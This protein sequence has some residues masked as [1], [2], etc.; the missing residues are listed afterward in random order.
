MK[1]LTILWISLGILL[2][3][4]CQGSLAEDDFPNIVEVDALP[5]DFPEV[6]VSTGGFS[7]KTG[8]RE[9]SGDRPTHRRTY[10]SSG[11]K[12]YRPT[13]TTSYRTSETGNYRPTDTTRY[14]TSETGNYRPTDTTNYRTSETGNYRPTVNTNYRTSETEND[15]STNG[16]NYRPTGTTT[17]RTSSSGRRQY[18]PHRPRPTHTRPRVSPGSADARGDPDPQVPPPPQRHGGVFYGKS[19]VPSTSRRGGSKRDRTSSSSSSYS[20][21]SSSKSTRTGADGAVLETVSGSQYGTPGSGIENSSYSYSHTHEGPGSS[22]HVTSSS[23]GSE[24]GGDVSSATGSS[25][26]SRGRG[27][28]RGRSRSRSKSRG[29]SRG[30]GRGRARGGT[31]GGDEDTERPPVVE[32]PYFR[33]EV[34]EGEDGRTYFRWN[35]RRYPAGGKV[36]TGRRITSKT[37]KTTK[38]T[39]TV[40]RDGKP[41]VSVTTYTSPGRTSVTTYRNSTIYTSHTPGGTGQDHLTFGTTGTTGTTGHGT[42]SSSGSSSTTSSTTRWTSGSSSSSATTAGGGGGEGGGTSDTRY[43][44]HRYDSR[45]GVNRGSGVGFGEGY[46]KSTEQ[47][48]LEYEEEEFDPEFARGP[49]LPE[50]DQN[51]PFVV[52]GFGSAPGSAREESKSRLYYPGFGDRTTH[53]CDQSSCYPATGNLLIG[54]EE[55]LFASST[56]G[57]YQRSR[58]CIVS[59]LKDQKKCFWC[60]SRSQ[61]DRS[62]QFSH[63]VNNIVYRFDPRTRRRSW[64]Q[65]DNGIQDVSIKLDLEAE[66]HFT[67]LIITF[68]TFRPAAMLIERSFDF[69]KTWKVY[70]YFAHNCADA[71]PGIPSG[72]P[73][74]I[75]DV[76][77]ESRYSAV[78]PSTEGEVI[79]RVLPP[80]IRIDNPYSDEVQNLLKITNLRVNF[81]KLHTLGDQLLDNRV[82]IKEKYYYAIYDMV[83]RGSCSCYGHASRCLPL[84]GV[85][86]QSDMVH[87]RC[88][89]THNTKG[90]NCEECQDFFNDL[91]WR[92]AVGKD[93][94]ACKKCNCNNHA[95]RCHFDENVYENSGRISGG[96]CDDCS[97][98]TQGNNCEQCIPYYYQD[99]SRDIRDPQ[100]CQ[101]CNCDPRGSIDDGICD[102][103]SDQI[104]GLLAGRCHC[105]TYVDGLKCD[106]CKAGYWN[107]TEENPEGCEV[108]TEDY[109]NQPKSEWPRK[110]CTCNLLGTVNN[111]GCD[112]YTGRCQCKRFVTGK[113]CNQ[114][115]PQHFGL[116]DHPDGCQP[117]NCDRGGAMDNDCDVITGQCKCRPHVTGRRCDQ[118]EEGYYV[119]S[120]NYL[121]YEAELAR[122]SELYCEEASL[123]DY[124][125]P[126]K[127][128]CQVV[129]REPYRD[130]RPTTWTGLGF[131]RVF[132]D[133]YLEF[134]IENVETSMEYD[135]VIRY[136]PQ[137]RN[138]WE[139]ARVIIERPGPVDPHGD[140]GNTHSTDDQIV[141]NL[142]DNQRDETLYPPVCLEAGKRYKIKIDFKRS[143]ALQ[144][145]AGASILVDS[146]LLIPRAERLPF[147]SGTAENDLLRREYE[148]YRCSQP[149]YS[150]G[151]N[152]ETIPEVCKDKHLESVGYYV[153]GQAFACQ[154][155]GTGSKSSLCDSFGGQC[156][157]KQNVVGRR[158]DRCAPGTYDF[159]PEG[160]KPCDCSSVGSL[161]NFCDQETGRCKCRPNTYGRQCDE[162]QPGFWNYPNCQRCEC[163]GHAD[164]CDSHTGKCHECR[165]NTS[166]PNCAYCIEGFYGDP[167]IDNGIACRPCPCPGT[168]DSGH[169]FADRCSLDPRTNDVVCEC[170]TGY[171]G[172]R[173]DACADNY[174]GNPEVPGGQCQS[175]Q[176]NNNIDIS[177]PGNCDARTGEC[178]QCLFNTYGNN[179]ER[180][181]PSYYGDALNQQCRQC[182][183]NLLGTETTED[184]CDH[185]TGQC[186]CLPNVLGQ[187]CDH[188]APNH[189]KIASGEG[190]EPC[191]CDPIGSYS[192]QCNEFD[193]QC[194]CKPGFGGRR[195]NQCQANFYGNPRVECLPCD[196]NRD[197]AETLQCDH[198]T[199]KCQCRLGI[200][201]HKCDVCDRGFTGR[202]PYCSPCG[203][204]FEN[205]D[206]ILEELKER[207][208][209]LI[210]AAS[211]IK[212]SGAT[213]AYSHEFESM[214]EHIEDV[215]EILLTANLTSQNLG[216]LEDLIDQLTES[217]SLSANELQGLELSVDNTTQRIS[218][219][220]TALVDLRL[221]AE[222]LRNKAGDLKEKATK[223]QEANVEGALNLT[224]IAE[225][226]SREAN[227][228]VDLTQIIVGES[229]RNRKRTELLL[230]HASDRFNRTQQENEDILSDLGL[231]LDE[232]EDSMP[233]LNEQVC[234]RRGN[235]CDAFC[236]G[237]GCN[238]KCGGLS[239]NDGLVNTAKGA[240]QFTEDAENILKKK[241]A[242]ADELLRGVSSAK[243][244][245]D[246]AFDL[247]K[248]AFDVAFDARNKSAGYKEAIQMLLNEIDEYYKTAGAKPD[249]IRILAEEVLKLDI[250]L[251]PE[252]ITALAEEIAST[253]DSLTNIDAIIDATRNDLDFANGLKERA[254]L[255]KAEAEG[256]LSVAE[257]VLKALEEAKAAQEA[258]EVALNTANNDVQ[259]ASTH[260]TQIASETS[261]AQTRASDSLKDVEDLEE[262]VAKVKSQYTIN[263]RYLIDANQEVS[264]ASL[265]AKKA[266]NDAAQLQ[267]SYDSLV[268]KLTIKSAETEKARNRAEELKKRAT[269]LASEV[270]TKLDILKELEEAFYRNEQKIETYEDDIRR[271]EISMV[272]YHEYILEK[273]E[274]YATCQSGNR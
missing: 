194:Q 41:S 243:R 209:A 236:G 267:D 55:K 140:C 90:L 20:Y 4:V 102:S 107:F 247:A 22:G 37:T 198:E 111:D 149:F 254:D 190:C 162:C 36:T 167:R 251:R 127:S 29:R 59:H 151:Q 273:T 66:F 161:D 24:G 178:L 195:C 174:Y 26:S 199:G 206:F 137:F 264:Q 76:V 146:I 131:M 246:I 80:N 92:P 245:S 185:E 87:G 191:A 200:G 88:E 234:D 62:P 91:P 153:F 180:C 130:G 77:C 72:P 51:H 197:G 116:S 112:V 150:G 189:W 217:L 74:A 186:P 57:L 259:K 97:H 129:M 40:G 205:W 238:G 122:G 125:S 9:V 148:Q 47:E 256:T 164:T 242:S 168:A 95:S 262:R 188:C 233:D 203:E 119:A 27:R 141:V 201:G 258:V 113:D 155:D 160:C 6:S 170:K 136:E 63:K 75:T 11:T 169:S 192:E 132:Q 100:I 175:C 257:R 28:G 56:C 109:H 53:P 215:R 17:H 138:I 33:G 5:E 103:R 218:L 182:V 230:L 239:C 85:K 252:Q 121:T 227:R 241:E 156:E 68:R 128:D 248:M 60:D 34:E 14:R 157:C 152:L 65:S 99:P 84:P 179:C 79:F 114:C 35:G 67:H 229:E 117:C 134:E 171:A 212:Q 15:R 93:S 8:H 83:V 235:P 208:K 222:E 183:C 25:S 3:L 124:R 110:K 50:E 244:Q 268:E 7:F 69:G 214:E 105:K 261:V 23:S 269:K 82:E 71:F 196:C 158:C 166:G 78:E 48:T 142:S 12:N 126:R 64:W 30:R 10:W 255:A 177:R 173:C 216:T 123:I 240:L 42:S 144:D 147:Y 96:V 176:C 270:N 204:C 260:L 2:V 1:R 165:D 115:L 18:R 145:S 94:N 43:T 101:P 81:T 61:W 16:T 120:L 159:G 38:T 202:A 220:N 224:R 193:G 98:N 272:E 231:K 21:T 184:V 271:M 223:L 70:R 73:S 163:N 172:A 226:R 228:Q 106:R 54:R 133:S 135:L 32:E 210:D 274:F 250:S 213:G 49:Q 154:C 52:R 118:S 253:I 219:A 225:Q 108:A 237:A 187:E 232:M 207:T 39:T 104:A 13:D 263:Q 139:G 265:K 44:S 58:Y 89:C 143:N 211:Q 86:D 181:R 221:Q 46:R 45:Y 19:R 266:A 31:D 249:E